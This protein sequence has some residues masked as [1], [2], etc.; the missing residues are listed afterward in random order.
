MTWASNTKQGRPTQVKC[1]GFRICT[2]RGCPPLGWGCPSWGAAPRDRAPGYG[3]PT[4][5]A[6]TRP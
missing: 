6:P 2:H 5:A 1:P 4:Q 3:V